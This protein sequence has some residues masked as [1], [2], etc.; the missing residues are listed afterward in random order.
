MQPESSSPL[1]Q[2]PA[3]PTPR[4]CEMC[5]N[6]A[7]FY[8][9]VL[10]APRPTAKLEDHRLSAVR[11]CL[12]N[13]FEVALHIEGRTSIRNLMTLHATVTGTHLPRVIGYRRL[14]YEVPPVTESSNQI[15]MQTFS[16]DIAHTRRG[17]L[18]K[19]L[20]REEGKLMV[21]LWCV[22]LCL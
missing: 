3:I 18:T 1:S 9:R 15:P 14:R 16:W 20:C 13:I 21:S 7:G 5:S 10:L 11:C 12:F 19:Y 6:V 8:G 22:C 4:P 17:D 2:V